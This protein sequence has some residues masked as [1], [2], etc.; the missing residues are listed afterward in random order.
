MTPLQK[1]ERRIQSSGWERLSPS[2]TK[3]IDAYIFGRLGGITPST[4]EERIELYGR[5]KQGR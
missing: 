1:V 2:E 3:I 5:A 4:P